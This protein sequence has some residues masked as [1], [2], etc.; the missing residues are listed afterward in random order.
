MLHESSDEIMG[1][2]DHIKDYISLRLELWVAY[3]NHKENMAN[4]GF[5]FKLPCLVRS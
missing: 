5:L 4:A 3:H 1:Q 2:L